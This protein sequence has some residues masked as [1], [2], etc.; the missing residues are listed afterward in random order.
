MLRHLHRLAN[1]CADDVGVAHTA[2]PE[3][4]ER[5]P[6]KTCIRRGAAIDVVVDRGCEQRSQIVFTRGCGREL[7]FWQS[8]SRP[9]VRGLLGHPGQ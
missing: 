9:D 2:K 7:V 3:I 6:R 5:I 4:V 8:P 1:W